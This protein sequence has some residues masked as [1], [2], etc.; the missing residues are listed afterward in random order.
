MVTGKWRK[1]HNEELFCSPN[2]NRV[3]TLITIKWAGH[4]A[5]MGEK[6]GV[7]R[8]LVWEGEGKTPLGRQRHRWE[9]NINMDY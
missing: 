1:L 4:I 8:V 5:H 6:R 2:I 7:C 3:I 9:D